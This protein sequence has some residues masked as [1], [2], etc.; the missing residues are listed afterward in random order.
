M[1]TRTFT[2]KWVRDKASY[3]AQT[4]LDTL[5]IQNCHAEMLDWTGLHRGAVVIFETVETT[6]V[7]EMKPE[8]RHGFTG[9]LQER[10]VSR[11]TKVL[12]SKTCKLRSKKGMLY[13]SEVPD[14]TA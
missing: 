1:S 11:I 12:C 14:G 10:T 2:E 3:I 13:W 7:T 8:F 4:D 9:Q 6:L 5:A